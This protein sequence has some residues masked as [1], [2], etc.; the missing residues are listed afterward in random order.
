G[1]R[2]SDGVLQSWIPAFAGMTTTGTRRAYERYPRSR[3]HQRRARLVGG[4]DAGEVALLPL[5]ADRMAMDVLAVGPELDL[6][7]RTHRGIAGG[8]VERRQGVPHLLRIGRAGALERVG[9]HEGLRHQA[10]RIFEEKFAVPLLVFGVD[11]LR[12]GV[13]VVI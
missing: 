7:A 9:D 12:V 13:D 11:L 6:A 1:P 5:H 4:K 2:A 8:N 10:A 3:L